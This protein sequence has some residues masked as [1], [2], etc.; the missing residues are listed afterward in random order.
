MRHRILV[1]G[2]DAKLRARLARLLSAAGYIVEIAEGSAHARRLRL[3]GVAL[4]IVV[5][6][7]LGP[8]LDGLLDE[9]G[10]ATGGTILVDESSG[11]P[12]DPASDVLDASDEAGLLARIREALEP[13]PKL[14]EPGQL[15]S[16][17]DYYLDLAGQSLFKQTGQEIE[18]TWGEYRLLRAFVQR[19]G[20]VLSRDHLLQSLSG[21]NAEAYDRSIDMQVVRLRR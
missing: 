16:F 5:P 2:R 11:S 18:L 12:T 14:D 1:V 7:G 6:A 4:S 10:A 15:L 9:L 20:R 17:A 21:Q 3:K 19:P 13:A 8:G